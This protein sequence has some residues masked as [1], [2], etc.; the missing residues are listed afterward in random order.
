MHK[1]KLSFPNMLLN[2]PLKPA[3]QA[4]KQTKPCPVHTLHTPSK[5]IF[6]KSKKKNLE[7]RRARDLLA[8]H[9]R[10]IE[11]SELHFLFEPRIRTL[12]V[13]ELV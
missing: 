7:K 9:R 1:I 2:K 3:D 10:V 12:F 4:Q 13:L 11:L 5:L 6:S 8:E